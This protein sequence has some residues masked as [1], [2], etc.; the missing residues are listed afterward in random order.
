MEINK[1]YN[2]DCFD[3]FKRIPDKSIDCIIADPPY[4][5]TACKWDTIIP[6][7]PMWKEI[8]RVIK[9]N[10]AICLFGS[11]PFS[12]KLRMSNIEMYKYD[13]IW[14]K[15]KPTGFINSK[16][17]P[18]KNYE[19]ISVFSN[20]KIGHKKLIN[21]RMIYNPQGIFKLE[22]KI[23]RTHR[24]FEGTS[25]RKSQT[26]EYIGE[27]SGF[28]KMILKFNNVIKNKTIHPTQKPVE[29]ISYLIRTYTKENELILD[30]CMGSGTT[31]LA[32]KKNNRNYIGSE[33]SKEYCSI[34]EERL[35][36]EYLF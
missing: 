26:N 4:G 25:E 36:Q 3:L 28:P 29:L 20:G 13:W 8:K 32:C 10:G 6:L 1:I 24:G 14:E 23:K 34:A 2:E 27:L 15:S 22:R 9:D 11:E 5:I 19:I 12:S 7:E 30:F 16:N 21:N 35:K 18:L 31:A 33:I 17:M